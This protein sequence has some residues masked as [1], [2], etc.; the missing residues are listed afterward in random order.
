LGLAELFGN[1]GRH[2]VSEKRV[3]LRILSFAAHLHMQAEAPPHAAFEVCIRRHA[4]LE[5]NYGAKS[6][7]MR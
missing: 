1:I 6:L 3:T 7:D 4:R 5:S 2:A